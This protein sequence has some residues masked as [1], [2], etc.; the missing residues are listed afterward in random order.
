MN[1]S[2]E[3]NEA[4]DLEISNA[5]NNLFEDSYAIDDLRKDLN[6]QFQNYSLSLNYNYA[7][8]L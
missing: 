1:E 3:M 5:V 8:L 2:N 6:E 4:K 7:K